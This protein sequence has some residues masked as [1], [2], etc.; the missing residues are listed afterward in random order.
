[1]KKML[2]VLAIGVIAAGML[3]TT[4]A[5]E[6]GDGDAEVAVL[7]QTSRAFSRVAKKAVPAVVFITVEKTVQTQQPG[8][9]YN[10]PFGFFGI[11][12]PR[13]PRQQLLQGQG[14]GFIITKDGYIL[15]N[16]HV[17][18]DADKITVKLNDGREFEA[19]RVGTDPKSE[20]AVIKIDAE[21][22]LP[23]LEAGDSASL[24][25]GEWVIAVGNPFGLSETLTVGVVSAIGRNNIGIAEYEDFIQTDAA[26]NPGNSGGPL[27]NIDGKVV[28]INTAIYSQSGGYMG[29]GFAIPIDL[30]IVIKD[31]LV[32]SGEV[33]RGFL[34]IQL[35]RQ[36]MDQEL[37]E[38]FGLDEAGGVL[39]AGIVEDSPAEEAGLEAGDI[40][41]EMDGNDV[42]DNRTFR[43]RVALTAPGKEIKLKIFRDGAVKMVKVTIGVL[44]GDEAAQK[45]AVE[46]SKK[47][48]LAVREL[49]PELAERFGHEMGEGVLVAE[50]EPYSAA[51]QAEIQP[52]H[53]ILS[54]NREPVTTIEAFSEALAEAAERGRVLLRIKSQ[55]YSWYALLRFE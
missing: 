10:D 1:M 8:F 7:K 24:E 43:N 30:A 41:L 42:E 45:K 2:R 47:L 51:A 14:S 22:D 17:V 3:P 52:G 28:G 11:P 13:R 44:P 49:S 26:I 19:E 20:V 32:A 6:V 50:V 34:G 4:G 5:K 55:R 23:I 54:V 33:T 38:S 12:Q 29:I 18:G 9:Q 36:E 40:I 15:T 25:M 21:G 31:Q 35:N 37:A 53:L 16:N 46:V 39:V 27:L 48:G